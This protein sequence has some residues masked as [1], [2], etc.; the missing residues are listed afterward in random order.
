MIAER[1][2][3]YPLALLMALGWGSAQGDEANTPWFDEGHLYVTEQLQRAAIW[4]DGFFGDPRMDTD[5]HASAYL[6]VIV[7]G[8]ASG[9]EDESDQG[10]R[11]RGGV[12]LPRLDRRLRLLVTSDAD[13]ALTGRELAGS[14]REALGDTNRGVGLHYLFRDRP[15]SKFSL[16]GGLSGGLSPELA[17][18]ARH[19]YTQPWSARAASHLTS[20]LY[21]KSEDGAGASSLLDYEWLSDTDTLWRYTLFGN[22]RE[23]HQGM[24]WSSQA[25]WARR[26]NDKTAIHLR[27][28]VSGETAA[29]R[30]ISEGWLKFLYRR[31]FLRS[32]LFY[33]V[34]PGLSWHEREDYGMEPT[35]AL[36]LEIQFRKD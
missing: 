20:T 4:F 13:D 28:G 10:V 23:D 16:G 36:R 8:F 21:W 9:V 6:N 34:E 19:R 27:A 32:W 29:D 22:V 25:K 12:D 3:L 7:E 18:S 5:T 11:F 24:E 17:L 35:L 14:E 2:T 30:R 33:E 1:T 31:N 26:L 15:N